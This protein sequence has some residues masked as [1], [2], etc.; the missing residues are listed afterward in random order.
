MRDGSEP[1]H[2]VLAAHADAVVLDREA[3]VVGVDQERDAQ[4][5]VIAEQVRAGDRFVTQLFA[6]VGGVRNQLADEDLLVGID[7]VDDQVEELGNIGLERP[8][9][10]TGL[11]NDG[12]GRQIP[13]EHRTTARA[14]AGSTPPARRAAPIGA[15]R[16]RNWSNGEE[17]QERTNMEPSDWSRASAGGPCGPRRQLDEGT[18]VAAQSSGASAVGAPILL[19]SS[20]QAP[21]ASSAQRNSRKSAGAIT[22][23]GRSA[24]NLMTC[25]K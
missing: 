8:A 12:H 2:H 5:R 1:L 11:I 15:R 17:F 21:S 13:L 24:S 16:S 7:R 10:A 22:P 18:S 14:G 19:A 23:A 6:G 3:F 4:G 9:F 25:V 20:C